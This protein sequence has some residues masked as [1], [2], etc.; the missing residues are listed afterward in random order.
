MDWIQ[1]S[2][3]P[4]Q[5]VPS[6]WKLVTLDCFSQLDLR[7]TERSLCFWSYCNVIPVFGINSALST[8]SGVKYNLFSYAN[9]ILNRLFGE[10]L[11]NLFRLVLVMFNFLTFL[12]LL[13]VLPIFIRYREP[14]RPERR[15]SSFHTNCLITQIILTTKNKELPHTKSSQ[16]ATKQ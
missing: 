15:K 11:I 6:L 3:L 12:F 13:D 8:L 7:V 10:K 5:E 9:D 14:T 2:K 1:L 16:P 4:T